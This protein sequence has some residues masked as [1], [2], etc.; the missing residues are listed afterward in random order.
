ME[1]EPKQ[2][3]QKIK[4]N[5]EQEITLRNFWAVAYIVQYVLG[6]EFGKDIAVLFVEKQIKNWEEG[7][8]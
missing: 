5:I 4:G 8:K 7:G 2:A 1:K 3:Y 6:E